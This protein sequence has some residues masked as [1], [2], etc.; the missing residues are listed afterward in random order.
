MD[1]KTALK[2]VKKQ[3]TDRRY[4]HTVRVTDTAIRLA[5]KYGVDCEKAELAGILHDY[6]KFRPKEE[7]KE[8]ITQES[9]IP[10]DLLAYN[11]ELWHAPVG[12]V[13]LEKEAGISDREILQAITSHT[14]GRAGMSRLEKVIFL[15]D[16]IEP[17]RNFPGVQEVREVAEHDLDAAVVRALRNTVGFLMEKGEKVYP[18]TIAAYNSLV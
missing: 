13:M 2:I 1:R 15:A 6:A 10:D 16:Y 17:G 3:L 18:D 12:A 5:G 11:L 9:R 14:T 4:E 7:M 8:M